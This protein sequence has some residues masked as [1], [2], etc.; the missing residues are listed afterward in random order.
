[1]DRFKTI[2]DKKIAHSEYGSNVD[3]V[4]SYDVMKHLFNF[5]SDF[6]MLISKAFVSTASV[7][8]VPCDLNSDRKVKVGLKRVLHELGLTDIKPEM[9]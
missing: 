9:E 7:S 6:Y 5:G 2:R 1:M 3:S 4:P 8:V